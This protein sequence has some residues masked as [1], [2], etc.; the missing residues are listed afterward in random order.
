MTVEANLEIGRTTPLSLVRDGAVFQSAITP[1]LA[2]W[3]SWRSEHGLELLVV[4]AML[5]V[6]LLVALVVAMK[7]PRDST[8][9]VGSAFLATIGVFSVTAASLHDSVRGVFPAANN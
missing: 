5:L 4:R 6:T 3:Q 2:S 1:E 9:L 8:A 7:R